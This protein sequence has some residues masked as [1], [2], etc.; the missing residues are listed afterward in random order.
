MR[1]DFFFK[2]IKS[3]NLQQLRI[4]T[5]INFLSDVHRHEWCRHGDWSYGFGPE[6]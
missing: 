1:I 2:K 6:N 5:I 3:E 4:D